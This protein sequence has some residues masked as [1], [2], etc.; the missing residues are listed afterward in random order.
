[1]TRNTLASYANTNYPPGTF[2]R[3]II[4]REDLTAWRHHRSCNSTWAPQLAHLWAMNKISVA[5]SV[6]WVSYQIHEQLIISVPHSCSVIVGRSLESCLLQ[7]FHSWETSF[8]SHGNE[9]WCNSAK[10]LCTIGSYPA[11]SPVSKQLQIWSNPF[12]FSICSSVRVCLK[13]LNDRSEAQ[14]SRF[15]FTKLMH[16]AISSYSCINGVSNTPVNWL[17]HCIGRPVSSMKQLWQTGPTES[18]ITNGKINNYKYSLY[19]HILAH[20]VKKKYCHLVLQKLTLQFL[21]CSLCFCADKVLAT[22]CFIPNS[23]R[24][25][26]SV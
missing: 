24:D 14:H 16:N 6:A 23:L 25:L 17:T 3:R 26:N 12:A 15:V 19:W 22:L 18:R 7:D 11:A 9:F 1:M 13:A 10:V 5:L 21:N 4:G 2:I 20:W 8:N